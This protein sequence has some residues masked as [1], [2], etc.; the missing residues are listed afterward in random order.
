MS[1]RV[2]ACELCVAS[3]S[4]AGEVLA[5]SC[6]SL[7]NSDETDRELDRTFASYLRSLNSSV[8]GAV[9]FQELL[10]AKIVEY[11]SLFAYQWAPIN[12]IS[13]RKTPGTNLD[14]S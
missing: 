8:I 10:S 12:L 6:L 4:Q 5:V 2:F 14:S 7:L 3:Q 11:S 1:N 9:A 13:M